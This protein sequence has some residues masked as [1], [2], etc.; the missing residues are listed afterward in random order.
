[1]ITVVTGLPRSGTTLMM[2]MLEAGGL[3]PYFDRVESP[4]LT[5]DNID[6]INLN[7]VLRETQKV[8]NL[9]NGDNRWLEQCHGKAVKILIPRDFENVPEGPEYRFIYMDRNMRAMVKSQMKFSLKYRGLEPPPEHE[10]FHR[11]TL[12]RLWGLSKLRDWPNSRLFVVNFEKAIKKPKATAIMV[13]AFLG[14]N[15]NIERM[16]SV[17]VK[18]PVAN[19]KGF[20]EEQIYFK[21]VYAISARNAID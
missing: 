3:P 4:F 1:M 12:A 14:R 20:L 18:R 5:I 9:R 2:R 17:V 10:I 13:S 16:V 19:F 11:N 15:L 7:M 8:K 6:Y 21:E